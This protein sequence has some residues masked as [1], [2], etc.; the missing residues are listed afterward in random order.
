MSINLQNEILL[1]YRDAAARIL[2]GREHKPLHVGT[3]HRWRGAG[4]AASGW[5]PSRWA[6]VGVRA[7]R[8][9][10]LFRLSLVKGGISPSAS[11]PDG[12]LHPARPGREP[13][14]SPSNV[15]HGRTPVRKGF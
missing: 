3:M 10:A 5:S 7:W 9:S 13:D 4:C 14:P 12:N 6:G 1:S 15:R 2:P 8:R 11:R